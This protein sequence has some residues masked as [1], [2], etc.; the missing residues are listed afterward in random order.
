MYLYPP[1]LSIHAPREGSDC[2][3]QANFFALNS[4]YPRSPRGERQLKATVQRPCN[5]F[6]STLPARGATFNPLDGK[7]VKNDFLSTLPARG[8]TLGRAAAAI[9]MSLSI[10]A[11]REGSDSKCAEK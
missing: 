6:L 8:A 10:H 7:G 1:L 11:P 4:F 9:N 3:H 5:I 2:A